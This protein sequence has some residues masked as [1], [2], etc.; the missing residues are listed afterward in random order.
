VGTGV[1]PPTPVRPSAVER[2]IEPEVAFTATFPKFISL[3]LPIES[4]AMMFAVAKAVADTW[5]TTF[6]ASVN[7][8]KAIPKILMAFFIIFF[9]LLVDD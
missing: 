8:T 9:L 1:A 2:I 4:G 5:A 7:K 6:E 3:I